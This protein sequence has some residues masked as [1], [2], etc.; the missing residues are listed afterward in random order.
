MPVTPVTQRM[1]ALYLP[2]LLCLLPSFKGT[3]RS[4]RQH[5]VTP[6]AGI[7]SGV[8]PTSPSQQH[9][10]VKP[11]PASAAS[12]PCLPQLRCSPLLQPHQSS[13]HRGP[14][15]AGTSPTLGLCR[16]LPPREPRWPATSSAFDRPSQICSA[17]A[18]ARRKQTILFIEGVNVEA[19]HAAGAALRRRRCL[20]RTCA[21][22]VVFAG[23]CPPG[24]SL[25][26][27]HRLFHRAGG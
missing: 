20:R 12:R 4:R 2:P 5:G 7:R 11:V 6:T 27:E 23:Q 19:A 21:Q 15:A 26:G 16:G 13:H 25:P 3:W 17:E 9:L 24:R 8:C 22:R 1:A 18:G 14:S 10:P